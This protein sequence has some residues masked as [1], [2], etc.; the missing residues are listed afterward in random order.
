MEVSVLSI[1]DAASPV[2]LTTVRLACGGRR[3]RLTN[4]LC[5]LMRSHG[6]P[7]GGDRYA[8]RERASLPRYCA[9]L[10]ARPQ[11]TCLGVM[12]SAEA[13][14]AGEEAGEARGEAGLDAQLE[15]P[16]PPK[17][18]AATWVSP[19]AASHAKTAAAAPGEEVK[20]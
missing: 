16:V 9:S 12:T 4:D 18:L 14:E 6:V 8:A 2:A 19:E 3:G 5:F 17:L 15:L 1:T 11:I 20:A 10:K 7:V 13:S